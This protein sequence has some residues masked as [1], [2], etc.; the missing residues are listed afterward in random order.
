VRKVDD[1]LPRIRLAPEIADS[2]I[3]WARSGLCHRHIALG[4]GQLDLIRGP[5]R[6]GSTG[7]G[8]ASGPELSLIGLE[9]GL[10]VRSPERPPTVVVPLSKRRHRVGRDGA[11]GQII[12]LTPVVQIRATV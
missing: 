12:P 6:K 2:L 11:C 1:D 7:G 5:V 3:A 8:A 10:I 4:H 9:S